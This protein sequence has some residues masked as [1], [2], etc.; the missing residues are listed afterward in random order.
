[1]VNNMVNDPRTQ[2][3]TWLTSYLTAANMKEDDDATNASFIITFEGADYELNRVFFDKQVDLIFIVHKPRTRAMKQH[4]MYIYGYEET[5]PI[6]VMCIDKT[7]ITAELLIWK[8]EAELR[9]VAE[10]YPFGS[11]RDL[12][13]A[14]E[15]KILFGATILYAVTYDLRYVR[16]KT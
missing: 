12:T 7:G 15:T 9:R 4:D 13:M 2:T 14:N 11:F 10:T 1:M 6:E 5:V 16:N 3:K 8:A